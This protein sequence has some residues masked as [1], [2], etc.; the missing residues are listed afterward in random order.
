MQQ[1]PA[2][3][4]DVDTDAE[5]HADDDTRYWVMARSR[6]IFARRMAGF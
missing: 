3:P 2:N 4:D 1:D 6:R 5:D